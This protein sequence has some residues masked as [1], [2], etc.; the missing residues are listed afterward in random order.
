MGTWSEESYENDA[1]YDL[2]SMTPDRMTETQIN[3]SIMRAH[4]KASK[5]ND[6][7]WDDEWDKT[8]LLGTVV[9]CLHLG[10]K[11]R[12]KKHLEKALKV[13]QDFLADKEYLAEWKTSK[14]RVEQLQKEIKMIKEVL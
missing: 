2:L 7:E 12:D 1:T 3:K 14:T 10:H 5:D 8:A 6:N 9:F 11:V 4:S 13:A